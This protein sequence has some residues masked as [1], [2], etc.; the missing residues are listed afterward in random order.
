MVV[1]YSNQDKVT[2]P[3][4]GGTIMDDFIKP[5]VIYF[6]KIR[7]NSPSIPGHTHTEKIPWPVHTATVLGTRWVQAFVDI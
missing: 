5:P 2:V 3:S 7:L 6:G 1:Y 4:P